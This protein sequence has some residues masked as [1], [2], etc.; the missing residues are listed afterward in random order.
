MS[1]FVLVRVTGDSRAGGDAGRADA[2]WVG[3]WCLS[4]SLRETHLRLEHRALKRRARGRLLGEL[5]K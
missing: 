1:D 2:E 4:Q 5:N 3:R